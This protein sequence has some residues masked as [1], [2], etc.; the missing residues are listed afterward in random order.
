[1]G[2]VRQI[3]ASLQILVGAFL[4]IFGYWIGGD[5]ARLVFFGQHTTGKLVGYREENFATDAGGVRWASASM[6]V[7]EFRAGQDTVRF[8]DWMGSN[9]RVP[10]GGSVPVL[11]DPARPANAVIDRPIWN[12]IPWAPM[13]A[14]ALLLLASGIRG[15]MS[16]PD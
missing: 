5:H 13:F 9:F 1:M 14:V 15:R 2:H 7:V 4:I 12:W 6:P 8:K 3:Q 16:P 11:Y 10:M